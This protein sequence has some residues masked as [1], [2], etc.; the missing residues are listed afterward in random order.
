MQ[1]SASLRDWL[2]KHQRDIDALIFDIDGVL[3]TRGKRNP[4][5]KEILNLLEQHGIP[6][7]LLTND[8]N[9][10]PMEKALHL[11]SAGIDLAPERIVSC[12]HAIAPLV[13]EK[14]IGDRLFFIMGDLGT[15]CYARAAG[16]KTTRNLIDLPQC[17]GVIVGEDNYDWEPTINAVVNF[18]IDTPAAL[19]IIPNPDEYYPGRTLTIRLAAGSVGALMVRA[20]HSYGLAIDPIYLGK[21]HRPIF[22]MAYA[23]LERLADRSI[24]PN[25]TLMVGDNLHADHQGAI[26]F[27]CLSAIVLTGLTT[28][29]MLAGASIKPQLVF[30]QL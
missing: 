28:R 21:P 12:A 4:G 30:N 29:T 1:V 3:L 8:G 19:L 23:Q 25:R 16:L 13:D 6:F 10:S 22:Q 14:K 20:L 11:Q 2:A 15:P 18:F 9:H 26:K 24:A 5:S 17:C 7:I 27:G